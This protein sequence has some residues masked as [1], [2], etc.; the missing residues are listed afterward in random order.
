MNS[1]Q[2]LIPQNSA[3]ARKAQLAAVL[4]STLVHKTAATIPL[5]P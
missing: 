1:I 2:V 3:E 4:Q 5:G